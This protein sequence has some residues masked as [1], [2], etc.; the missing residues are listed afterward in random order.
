MSLATKPLTSRAHAGSSVSEV[1]M[2]VLIALLPGVIAQ[3]YFF[4]WGTLLNI[5]LCALGCIA[6]ETLALFLRKTAASDIRTNLM[7]LSALVTAVLLGIALPSGAPWWIPLLGSAFC[8][9]ASQT[10]LWRPRAKPV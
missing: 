9:I 5:F 6:S 10:R 2:W 1:M 7:D 3:T 4:G 8:D